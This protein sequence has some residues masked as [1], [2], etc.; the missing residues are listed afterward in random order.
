MAARATRSG[1]RSSYARYLIAGGAG[2]GVDFGV[3]VGLHSGAGAPLGLSVVCAYLTSA[4]VNYAL[5]RLW[6]FSPVM[7]RRESGRARQYLL[8]LAA[9]VGV[10][11]V[12]V[13]SLANLGLDYRIAK[14]ISAVTLAVANYIV[15]SRVVMA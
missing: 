11:F 8:L 3:L 4:V 2:F 14:V 6:V 10:N 9:N 1:T 12:I 5:L 13:K 15:A 7:L